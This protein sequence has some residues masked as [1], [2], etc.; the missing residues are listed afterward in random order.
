M[1]IERYPRSARRLHAAVYIVTLLLLTTGWLLLIGREGEPSPL[2][3]LTGVPD[4]TL[5]VW[6]WYHNPDGL[7]AGMNPLVKPFNKG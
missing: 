5:H 6:L 4:V 1:T 7:Y 3:A 2:A